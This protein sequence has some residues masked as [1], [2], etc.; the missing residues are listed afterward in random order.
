LPQKANHDEVS[1]L[2]VIGG[3]TVTARKNRVHWLGRQTLFIGVQVRERS[4]F[5]L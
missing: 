3:S 5:E 4:D 1:S 2:V